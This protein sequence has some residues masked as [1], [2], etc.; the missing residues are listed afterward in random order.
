MTHHPIRRLTLVRHG[1]TVGDSSI[2]YHGVNDVALSQVGRAQMECVARA[3]AEERFEAVY[4]S[5]L[6]RTRES[7]RII[8]PRL[9]PRPLAGFN[10]INFGRWEGLTREEI[11]ARDPELFD[12]WRVSNGEFHYPD[13]DR[14]SDFRA[15]VAATWREILPQAPARVLVVAHRGVISTI[16][17]E[18]LGISLPDLR[19][20]RLGL[21]SIHVLVEGGAGWT[22]ELADHHD[23][24]ESPAWR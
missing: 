21:G 5:T 7:A 17:M 2:R 12:L 19:H 15:R 1:E 8:A 10:E 13:G 11:E 3:L 20:W 18:T 4:T 22:A 16:L 24:L 9:A 23:H 14:V 6:R